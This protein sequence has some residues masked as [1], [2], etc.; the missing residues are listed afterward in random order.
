MELEKTN[1]SVIKSN[2][3]IDSNTLYIDLLNNDLNIVINGSLSFSFNGELNCI[4]NN[5]NICFDS[6]NGGIY[7]NSRNGKNIKNL[8]ESIEYRKNKNNISINNNSN[9]M[10]RIE[11]LEEEIR[12]I[13]NARD[14]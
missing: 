10:K 5:D 11:K 3:D 1:K 4:T 9:L 8:P 14:C 6:I 13:K 12:N 2:F 7:L